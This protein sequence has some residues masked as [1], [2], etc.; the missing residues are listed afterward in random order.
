MKT[1]LL[2]ALAVPLLA[3]CNPS[4]PPDAYDVSKMDLKPAPAKVDL[5]K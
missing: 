4:A 5:S 1:I 3:A 2:A